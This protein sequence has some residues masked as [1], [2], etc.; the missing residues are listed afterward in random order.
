M[1]VNGDVHADTTDVK[2]TNDVSNDVIS[3]SDYESGTTDPDENCRKKEKYGVIEKVDHAG[4]TCNVKWITPS[5]D[6]ES[7]Y[8]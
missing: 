7:R 6:Y 2:E 8:L 3:I 1:L 4:R 5:F